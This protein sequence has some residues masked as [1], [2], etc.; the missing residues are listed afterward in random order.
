[1]GD[2][3][4]LLDSTKSVKAAAVHLTF[5]RVGSEAKWRLQRPDGSTTGTKHTS[6]LSAARWMCSHRIPGI[7]FVRSDAGGLF[8]LFPL[9]LGTC[10]VEALYLNPPEVGV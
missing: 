6:G 1:M 5:P 9:E 4:I 10:Q 7:V 2:G 8:A 3:A